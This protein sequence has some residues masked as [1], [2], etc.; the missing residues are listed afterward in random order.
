MALEGPPI[1]DVGNGSVKEHEFGGDA[2]HSAAFPLPFHFPTK[3]TRRQEMTKVLG[4]QNQHELSIKEKKQIGAW[5]NKHYDELAVVDSIGKQILTDAYSKARF[6]NG[7]RVLW[8]DLRMMKKIAENFDHIA[9]G[10]QDPE[11]IERGDVAAMALGATVSRKD[12]VIRTRYPSGDEL[13]EDP[14]AGITI[15]RRTDGSYKAKS[16][17]G[18]EAE[19]EKDGTLI[20]KIPA[21]KSMAV[22]PSVLT[23]RSDGTG[24]LVISGLIEERLPVTRKA[25][26]LWVIKDQNGGETELTITEHSSRVATTDGLRMLASDSGIL[27]TDKVAGGLEIEGKPDGTVTYK[28]GDTVQ[29]LRKSSDDTISADTEVGHEIRYPND[30]NLVKDKLGNTTVFHDRDGFPIVKISA[31][32]KLTIEDDQNGAPNE[33]IEFSDKSQHTALLDGTA[34]KLSKEGVL[35]LRVPVQ[36]GRIR[37]AEYYRIEPDGTLDYVSPYGV[38]IRFVPREVQDR[39]T[40]KKP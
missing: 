29:T 17:K 18:Y 8:S 25:D 9:V 24:E 22:A 38:M 19:R 5:L 39:V 4:A 30:L 14:Q 3:E 7:K 21:D 11:A 32:G 26:N 36:I 15:G 28:D 23:L 2:L 37:S 10:G 31:D 20:Y 12:G 27:I 6:T 40:E 35:S 33:A 1:D 13:Q 34:A 16:D